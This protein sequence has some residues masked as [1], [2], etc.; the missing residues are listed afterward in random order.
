MKNKTDKRIEELEERIG[1]IDSR[2]DFHR[3]WLIGLIT[4]TVGLLILVFVI[5][6]I[7][8][9]KVCQDKSETIRVNKTRACLDF[10]TEISCL[11]G[12]D[13]PLKVGEEVDDY[14]CYEDYCLVNLKK[15]ICEW[16]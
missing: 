16:E 2:L 4:V 14:I 9:E 5:S 11:E 15:E 7:M 1:D 10:G 13:Y 6:L 3:G 12:F 8:P